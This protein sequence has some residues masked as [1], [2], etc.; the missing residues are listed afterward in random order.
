MQVQPF[1][2]LIDEVPEKCIRVLINREKAGERRG[3]CC[4]PS[5]LLFDLQL[6]A[7]L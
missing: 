3:K 1:A 2:S 5:L 4:N 6:M 7:R